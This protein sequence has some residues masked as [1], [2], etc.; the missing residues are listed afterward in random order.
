MVKRCAKSKASSLQLGELKRTKQASGDNPQ[1]RQP[2]TIKVGS[3][4]SGMHGVVHAVDRLFADKSKFK[5]VFLSD[6]LESSH[7]LS[8]FGP[9]HLKPDEFYYDVLDRDQT[10]VLET[11]LYAWTPP[12]QTFSRDGLQQGVN[13]SRGRLL[14]VGIKYVVKKKPSTNM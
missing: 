6:I 11:H 9:D 12:C 8:K 3:D 7:K 10:K 2:K 4:F 14:G 13:D 5:V 1:V